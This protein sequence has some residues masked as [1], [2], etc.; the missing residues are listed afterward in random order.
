[1][2]AYTDAGQLYRYV[3]ALFALIAEQEPGA[4]DAVLASRLVIRLRC[5]DPD[6]EVTINGRRRPL[7]TTFGPTNLR[8]TLDIKLAPNTLHA[9]MLGDLGLKQALADGLLEVRGPVWK[10]K[11]LADLFQQAQG[12]YRQVLHEQGWPEAAEP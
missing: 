2:A 10:A 11:A 4:A 8:P 12:L 3:Q 1:M 7:E 5:T 6:A 9:I